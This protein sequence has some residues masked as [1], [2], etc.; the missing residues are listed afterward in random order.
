MDLTDVRS[1]VFYSEEVYYDLNR[2]N[3]LILKKDG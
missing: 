2:R 3:N 1:N